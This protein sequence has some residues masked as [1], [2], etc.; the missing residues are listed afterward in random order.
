[1]KTTDKS[2]IVNAMNE[3]FTNVS[4]GKQAVGTA[5]TDVDYSVL[6]PTNPTFQQLAAAIGQIST[7]K[8]WAMGTANKISPGLEFIV[9]TN[10]SKLTAEYINVSGLEFSPKTIYYVDQ[11]N[12]N[13]GAVSVEEGWPFYNPTNG[14]YGVNTTSRQ[15]RVTGNCY[16]SENGFQV[17]IGGGTSVVWHWIAFE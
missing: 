17:P 16:I 8:K 4:N 6:V 15:Y 1:M 7:G 5:I 12:Y 14:F 9:N 11:S 13:L 3:L 10:G 2:S